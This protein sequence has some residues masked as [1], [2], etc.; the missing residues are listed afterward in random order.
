M[1]DSIKTKDFIKT[2]IVMN[3]K[4]YNAPEITAISIDLETGFCGSDANSN[5]IKFSPD[6]AYN[7]L[8]GEDD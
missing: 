8:E 7:F 5:E 3:K 2:D 6:E 1:R 4:N